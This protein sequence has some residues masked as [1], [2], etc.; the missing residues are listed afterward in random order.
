MFESSIFSSGKDEF[1]LVLV[2]PAD[3]RSTCYHH[4][5]TTN[6]TD[7]ETIDQLSVYLVT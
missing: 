3:L 2:R 4:C 1:P 5:Q 7:S 6:L